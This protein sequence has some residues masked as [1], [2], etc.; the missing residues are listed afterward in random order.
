MPICT[1]T[2]KKTGLPCTKSSKPGIEFCG[3]HASK[4]PAAPLT[5]GEQCVYVIRGNSGIE[6]R[7]DKRQHVESQHH[8]CS[9]HRRMRVMRD[10][11][12]EHFRRIIDIHRRFGMELWA[13]H[14]EMHRGNVILSRARLIA[15]ILEISGGTPPTLVHVWQAMDEYRAQHHVVIN[16]EIRLR[17]IATDAQSIHTRE[18]TMQH[19]HNMAILLAIPIPEDQRTIEFIHTVWTAMFKNTVDQRIYDDMQK[20]YDTETCREI[21]DR[22]YRKLLDHLVARIRLVEDTATVREL[23]KRLQQ[24]C[25][26]SV[27][28]CCD[29]HL[30]RLT[31]V[32]VGFDDAFKQDMPKGLILQE[33]MAKI[34]LIED[35]E[36]RFKAATALFGELGLNHEEAGPW[37][38]AISE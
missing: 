10:Q 24:E 38:D 35:V 28:M 15:R 29:G 30:N 6:R 9:A 4:P 20:W 25:A 5:D 13:F 12:R 18:V 8:E 7:C 21:G 27:M 22:L 23:Y 16:P 34:A 33:K 14:W 1:A 37:L 31:N 17:A 11:R 26:E 36:E 32:M 2:V 3:I 19:N